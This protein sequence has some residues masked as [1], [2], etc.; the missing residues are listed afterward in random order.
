MKLDK[1]RNI[2][3]F[4]AVIWKRHGILVWKSHFCL[5]IALFVSFKIV[6]WYLKNNMSYI[7]GLNT[8]GCFTTFALPILPLNLEHFSEISSLSSFFI[9]FVY[10]TVHGNKFLGQMIHFMM[11]D[12]SQI[13]FYWWKFSHGI[14]NESYYNT[15][16]CLFWWQVRNVIVYPISIPKFWKT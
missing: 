15:L 10:Q 2:K 12:E 1:H 3:H 4:I 5:K 13:I 9:K 14:I 11:T 7:G 16:G 6:L 8:Q